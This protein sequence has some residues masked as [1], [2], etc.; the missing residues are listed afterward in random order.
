M[1]EVPHQTIPSQTKASVSELSQVSP[2]RDNTASVVVTIH[3]SG[4]AFQMGYGNRMMPTL[5]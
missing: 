3:H 5:H 4:T 2:K 1:Y